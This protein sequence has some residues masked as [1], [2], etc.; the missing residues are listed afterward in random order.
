MQAQETQIQTS[1]SPQVFFTLGELL[2]DSKK[3]KELRKKYV[4]FIFRKH[5]IDPDCYDA[6][7]YISDTDQ[8]L[9]IMKH[10]DHYMVCA[11]YYGFEECKL[12]NEKDALELKV[13]VEDVEEQSLAV[14]QPWW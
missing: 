12:F 6:V 7:I 5:C 1:R 9:T 8:N 4:Y 3:V 14:V 10:F 13:V 11:E 2:G